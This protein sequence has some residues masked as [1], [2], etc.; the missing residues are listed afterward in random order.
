MLVF[1]KICWR[2]SSAF[3]VDYFTLFSS[4]SIADFEQVNASW[5]NVQDIIALIL[6]IT[7]NMNVPDN[8]SFNPLV[9]NPNI[10][11]ITMHQR[12]L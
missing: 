6:L 11:K 7:L 1:Q 3:I 2:R 8:F 12:M 4:V 10:T 9:P 5:F